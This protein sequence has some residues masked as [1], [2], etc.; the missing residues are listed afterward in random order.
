MSKSIKGT[1]LESF[2]YEIENKGS[3]Q[4]VVD[5]NHQKWILVND[6]KELFGF[7]F[8]Q[9]YEIEKP[10]LIEMTFPMLKHGKSADYWFLCFE[11]IQHIL[12]NPTSWYMTWLRSD[13]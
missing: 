6:L 4:V 8:K 13:D 5:E 7:E 11:S 10:D 12:A 9:W 2:R 1:I 3:L